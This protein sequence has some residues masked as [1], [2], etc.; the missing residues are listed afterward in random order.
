M[1]HK[2]LLSLFKS[3]LEQYTDNADYWYPLCVLKKDVSV[4]AYDL[5]S[6]YNDNV[7]NQLEAT[8]KSYNI[9]MAQAFQM[10]NDN[11]E[12]QEEDLISLLYK[13][14]RDGY[15]FPWEVETYYF[16][17]SKKWMIYV[18]HEWTIT[19]TGDQIT[20]AAKANIQ[21]KYRYG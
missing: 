9:R 18:S 1:C 5:R 16:D 4:A 19:F 20:R 15:T 14:D 3:F 21:E 11:T 2:N 7:I 8:L 6:I 13:K 10:Q 17:N 12:M